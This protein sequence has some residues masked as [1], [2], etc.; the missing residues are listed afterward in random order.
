MP[1]MRTERPRRNFA[2]EANRYDA[3]RDRLVRC[4]RDL[5]ERGDASKVSVTDITTEMG[6]TRG[7]FYYY[8]SGKE[9]L[10][11][12]IV[13]TYLQDLLQMI[14]E[15]CRSYDDREAAIYAIVKGIR[16]WLY[17]DE[18]QKRPMWHVLAEMGLGNY[19][20]KLT[21]EAVADVIVQQGLLT[22]YGKVDD[23]ALLSHANLV[24]NGILGECSLHP[25]ASVD[26]ICEAACA[27]LRYRKRRTLS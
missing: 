14:S 22:K 4:A 20:W 21:C 17:D 8:F 23:N 26:S 2:D 24:A 12:S 16:A 19:T 9:E 3:K 18:G 7:L 5:A 1:A 10:N 15:E 6:I 11:E 13:Q 25:E 27:S